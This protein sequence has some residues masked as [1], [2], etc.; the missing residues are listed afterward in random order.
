MGEGGKI[1]KILIVDDDP[2]Q[3]KLLSTRLKDNGFEVTATTEA[4][5][6]LKK[7]TSY[8]YDLI[9]LDVMM[10]LIN[11]YNLCRLLKSMDAHKD[12]PIILATSR[13]DYEDIK[14]G[15]EMGAEAYLTKP[16]R[17][18]EL[19]KTIRILEVKPKEE[20]K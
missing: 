14:I 17:M 3:I 8:I 13:D 18:E 5:E 19:L 15:L 11:G 6:G 1:K 2:V 20:K 4:D 7:A 16:V 10:P 12:I 9:I